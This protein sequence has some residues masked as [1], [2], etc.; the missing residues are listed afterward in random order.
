LM[1]FPCRVIWV[2]LA[3]SQLLSI[4]SLLYSQAIAA[5]AGDEVTE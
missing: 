4:S 1:E 3:L 5:M 2:E